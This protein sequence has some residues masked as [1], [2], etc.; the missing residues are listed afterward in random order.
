MKCIGVLR[1]IE[2]HLETQKVKS[3]D[4]KNIKFHMAVDLSCE[5]TRLS[6][7]WYTKL[8]DM[9]DPDDIADSV[10][11]GCFSR[12][13]PIYESLA[14]TADKDAVARGPEFVAKLLADIR[15]R[16]PTVNRKRVRLHP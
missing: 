14:Q 6:K 9:A 13:N 7:P 1:R 4:A 10:V 5:L 3:A 16:F 2:E 15:Q 12:V 11:D 8:L